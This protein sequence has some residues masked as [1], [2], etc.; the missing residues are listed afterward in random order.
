MPTVLRI[1][2]LRVAI[3]TNDHPPPHVHG[4]GYGGEALFYLNCP[5][6]PPTLRDKYRLSDPKVNRMIR[7]L[8][9]YIQQL[10]T[11]WEE[12]YGKQEPHKP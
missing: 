1:R 4:F 2:H 8:L 10:C 7:A 3:H 11:T 6:G 12:M 9:P 5:N